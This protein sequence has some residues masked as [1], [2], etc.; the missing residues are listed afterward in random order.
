[1]RPW[2][3]FNV[4][5]RTAVV[6]VDDRHVVYGAGGGITADS[7]PVDENRELEAK[8]AVLTTDR[9][10][11]ASSRRCACEHGEVLHLDRHLDRL[12]DSAHH[13]DFDVD[14]AHVRELLTALVADV[15]PPHR[16][17]MVVARDGHIETTV[18]PIDDTSSPGACAAWRP[19]R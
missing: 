2:S 19:I 1:M 11:S 8:S 9:P 10:S 4:A 13:F 18:D 15:Q 12:V 16:L 3:T 17:R 5:I 6:R 7:D 14:P